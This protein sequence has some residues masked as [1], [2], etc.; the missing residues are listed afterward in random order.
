MKVFV[1]T[2]GWMYS[3]NRGNN[4]DWYIENSGLNSVELNMS[5]YRFPFPSQVKS[6]AT[7]GAKLRWAIK[8]SR[9]ITHLFKFSD[10]GFSSWQKFADLFSP[11]DVNI[12]FY[13][14]Q[15]PPSMK[16]SIAPKLEE[17]VKKTKLAERFALEVRN[18]NWFS[19]RWIDWATKL[20]LTWVS[21]DSPDFPL[22]VYNTSGSVY[23]RIHGRRSWYSHN[24]SDREL[25]EIA[26]KIRAKKPKRVHVFFNN[27]TNMRENAVRMLEI[28]H[29]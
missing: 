14:F 13:L 19:E 27:D 17:F 4:L 7:K 25:E 28:L 8:A 9:F 21:I 29:R 15:I 10:K 12:D 1:G 26:G 20:G 24:Y 5:Y 2:S 6:W 3:W 23:E 11:M 22:E 16:P 18:I